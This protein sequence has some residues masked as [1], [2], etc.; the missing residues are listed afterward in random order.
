MYLRT[1]EIGLEWA[2]RS[3]GVVILTAAAGGAV[4]EG[5][6]QGAA[7]QV[8]PGYEYRVLATAKTST[9]EKEL[10]DGAEAGFRFQA[11]MWRGVR[12]AV[13]RAG[14]REA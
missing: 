14:G 6:P 9:M 11:S 10:N 4:I 3:I 1:H 12:E 8:A 7:V 5:G 2:V 13:S